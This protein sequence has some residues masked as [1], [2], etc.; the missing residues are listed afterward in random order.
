MDIA[1]IVAYSLFVTVGVII[2]Y[3]T[4][5]VIETKK[6][7]RFGKKFR[8]YADQKVKTLLEHLWGEVAFVNTLY[9]RGVDEV[10]K[11][12]IDPVTKPIVETQQKY[13]TLKT[14]KREI[15][16][17]EKKSVSTHLQKIAEMHKK[18]KKKER[19]KRNRK[20]KKQRGQEQEAKNENSMPAT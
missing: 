11:D 12:L 1:G 6:G 16:H 5:I 17:A 7:I 15:V 19:Q 8:Q 9:E 20:Q 3:I 4:L 2:L 14:G 13:T 18:N 10:E